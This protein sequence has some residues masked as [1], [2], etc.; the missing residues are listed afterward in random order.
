MAEKVFW[1]LREALNALVSMDAVLAR[2][3]RM[4][5]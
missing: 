4:S 3:I 1:M 5:R 2:K